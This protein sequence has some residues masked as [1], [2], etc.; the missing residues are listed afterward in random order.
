MS[1]DVEI[2]RL[3]PL[4]GPSLAIGPLDGL[5]HQATRER[6]RAAVAADVHAQPQPLRTAQL[7]PRED[8][9]LGFVAAKQTAAD[10]LGI[11]LALQ[12][13]ALSPELVERCIEKRPARFTY[14]KQMAALVWLLGLVTAITLWFV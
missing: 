5:A 8:L 14:P 1:D 3:S 2:L 9:L 11:S 4:R 13:V 12:R 10:G 7:E 6:N